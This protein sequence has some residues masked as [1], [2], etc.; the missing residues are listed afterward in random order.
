MA[1]KAWRVGGESASHH[2]AVVEHTAVVL[3]N[4]RLH[5][6]LRKL[7]YSSSDLRPQLLDEL[8]HMQNVTPTSLQT[9]SDTWSL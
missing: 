5:E 3:P 4:L 2:S 6:L 8:E 9:L 1:L 7:P